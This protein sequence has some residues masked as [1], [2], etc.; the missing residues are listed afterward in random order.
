MVRPMS[1]LTNNCD[2]LDTTLKIDTKTDETL[3]KIE[4]TINL[5]DSLDDSLES[6]P[7]TPE[8][9]EKRKIIGSKDKTFK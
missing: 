3:T 5:D 2:Q 4:E 1:P 9:A 7:E 6:I 8:F